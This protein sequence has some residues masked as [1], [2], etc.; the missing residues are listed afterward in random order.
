ML[1]FHSGWKPCFGSA[2]SYRCVPSNSRQAVRVGREVR[3]HPVEYHADA[4]L[5]QVIDQIHEVLRRPVARGR[6]EIAGGLVAPR[7]IE[8]M[9]RDRH[10]FDMGE[11]G[12]QQVPGELMRD[13][14]VIEDVAV[15][16]PPGT[17]VQLVDRDRRI[18]PV[19][20]AAPCH[21]ARVAPLVIE[22]PGARGGGRRTFG[23][24]R[25]WV[26]LVGNRLPGIRLDAVLV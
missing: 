3:G 1:E 13:L 24:E 18:E 7:A 4:V 21:P 14:A 19:A 15:L 6:R 20:R 17:H 10:Q 25:E 23:K 5:V 9:L 16:A 12:L 11:S 22:R 8:R 2:C 26:G